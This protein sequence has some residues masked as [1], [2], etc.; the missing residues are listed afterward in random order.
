MIGITHT[1]IVAVA[2]VL[3]VGGLL[4]TRDRAT[5]Q[6]TMLRQTCLEGGGTMIVRG[7]NN[8]DCINAQRNNATANK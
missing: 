5:T 7:P 6:E 3:V 1:L 2:L 4:Y 8:H